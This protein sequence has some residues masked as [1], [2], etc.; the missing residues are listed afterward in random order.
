[1]IADR[2]ASFIIWGLLG[3]EVYQVGYLIVF[4][5]QQ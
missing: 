2:T 5:L 3:V 4:L 1:M